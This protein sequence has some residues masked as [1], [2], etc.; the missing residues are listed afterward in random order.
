MQ[1]NQLIEIT[2]PILSSTEENEIA[3]PEITEEKKKQPET[4]LQWYASYTTGKQ[5]NN[6]A[7]FL[8]HNIFGKIPMA[9]EDLEFQWTLSKM[10]LID[11]LTYPQ[12]IG[13]RILQ[14]RKNL[15]LLKSLM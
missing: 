9:P 13:C 10:H 11:I 14:R 2:L 3:V 15:W 5:L 7:L 8:L 4:Q 6:L 1:C 12:G